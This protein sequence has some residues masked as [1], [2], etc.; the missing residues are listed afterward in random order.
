[1]KP[2]LIFPYAADDSWGLFD[3][4]VICKPDPSGYG[5]VTKFGGDLCQYGTCRCG[6]RTI[7][8]AKYA[9]CAVC[10]AEVYGT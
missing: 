3:G 2:P 7:S 1:M 6:V 9:I 4:Y 5:A 8:V 10:G